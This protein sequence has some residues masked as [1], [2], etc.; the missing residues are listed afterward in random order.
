MW[1]WIT[2]NLDLGYAP[3]MM[4][5]VEDWDELVLPIQRLTSINFDFT[6]NYTYIDNTFAKSQEYVPDRAHSEYGANRV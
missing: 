6:P 5:Q 2:T 4:T 3:P 1:N